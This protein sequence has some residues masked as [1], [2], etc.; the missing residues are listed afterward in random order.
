MSGNS[1]VTVWRAHKFAFSGANKEAGFYP[2][3]DLTMPAMK[4]FEERNFQCIQ[5]LRE[6]EQEAE[7]ILVVG[8]VAQLDG[9]SSR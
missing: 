3:P 2:T 1:P 4:S 7:G 5:R 9:V 6:R 8:L